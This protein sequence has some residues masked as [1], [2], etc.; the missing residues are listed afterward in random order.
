VKLVLGLA[1]LALAFGLAALWQDELRASLRGARAQERAA[2][3]LAPLEDARQRELAGGWSRLTVGRPSGREALWPVAGDAAQV[4]EPQR[5]PP[6]QP[7]E[8][9]PVAP[10]AQA[11]QLDTKTIAADPRATDADAAQPK[12]TK[13][14]KPAASQK[15]STQQNASAPSPT[16]AP[17]LGA[18]STS[19]APSGS[20]MVV[21]RGQT[22]HSIAKARYGR[23]D[24]A[25]IAALAKHNGLADPA[26]LA[27][28]QVLA[29]PALATLLDT[30][31]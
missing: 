3:G 17:P 6:Q 18:A 28:G 19:A 25:L 13:P 10:P 1:A 27:V 11:A 21:E 2:L 24:A 4:D 12:S 7:P 23:A 30:R 29:L 26:Q 20:K 9:P 5:L 14:S 15:P 22:L 16:P 8:A 31:P